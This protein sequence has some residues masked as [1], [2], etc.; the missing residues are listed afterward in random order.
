MAE[1]MV[2]FQALLLIAGWLLFLRAQAELRAQSARHSLTGELEDLRQ[3][4]DALLLRLIE[5]AERAERC[6]EKLK[7]WQTEL[8]NISLPHATPSQPQDVGNPP[9]NHDTVPCTKAPP[10]IFRDDFGYNSTE[11][12]SS[13]AGAVVHLA[14]QG[15]SIAEIAR[16]TG[17][18]PGEV[19]L[20]LNLKR[21]HLEEQG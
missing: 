8:A 5:E 14:E 20:I 15:L 11:Q 7:H 4:L 12:E 16:K 10:A 1:L 2:L 21:R 19:E 18:A 13:V 9:D 3:T 6:L 17:Y